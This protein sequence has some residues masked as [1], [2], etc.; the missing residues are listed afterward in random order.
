MP[1]VDL[2][3]PNVFHNNYITNVTRL[4]AAVDGVP[5]TEP[6]DQQVRLNYHYWPEIV[7]KRHVADGLVNGTLGLTDG[8]KIIIL[9]GGFGWLQEA[10]EEWITADIVTT[11]TSS[12][13][14]ANKDLPETDEI[15]AALD[16]AGVTD[17][18]KRNNYL[19]R[20]DRGAR[21]QRTIYNEDMSSGTS[22]GTI[23]QALGLQGNAKADYVITEQVLPWLEDSECSVVSN[24]AHSIAN[25]V[26]H[27]LTPFFPSSRPEPAP[28]WNWKH[29]DLFTAIQILGDEYADGHTRPELEAEPWYTTTFWKTLLPNDL[30][31]SINRLTTRHNYEIV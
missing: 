30:F 20:F 3:D 17:P 21:S 29:L 23:K 25:N 16:A 18:T 1:R 22:R 2:S 8:M 19:A 6:K 24:V 5:N 28:Y 10:L 13:V 31:I 4:M 9:G 26:V 27:I 12:Y 14:H 15:V 7:K 11:D